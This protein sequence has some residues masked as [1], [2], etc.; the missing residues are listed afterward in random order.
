MSL[1]STKPPPRPA[2]TAA[3][4]YCLHP[5]R[6][7]R[8]L[9]SACTGT[10]T[11]GFIIENADGFCKSFAAKSRT[12]FCGYFYLTVNFTAFFRAIVNFLSILPEGAEFSGLPHWLAVFWA[13]QRRSCCTGRSARMAA[14]PAA[15]P[16]MARM[17]RPF[18][19]A[20]I[21]AR[22]GNARLPTLCPSARK[23]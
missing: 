10:T 16:A 21:L 5:D 23:P 19:S 22:N 9:F 6:V 7:R 12:A 1:C 13:F 18:S 14:N 15:A 8:S 4:F 17:C 11:H 2:G 3:V 20:S